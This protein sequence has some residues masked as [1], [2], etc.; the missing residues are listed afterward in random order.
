MAVLLKSRNT[1]LKK[2][3]KRWHWCYNNISE[4]SL[5]LFCVVLTWMKASDSARG[6]ELV[7]SLLIRHNR[8]F[9]TTCPVFLKTQKQCVCVCVCDSIYAHHISR[10]ESKSGKTC[11]SGSNWIKIR[12][13]SSIYYQNKNK[14]ENDSEAEKGKTCGASKGSLGRGTHPW[15]ERALFFVLQRENGTLTQRKG[16]RKCYTDVFELKEKK[17]KQFPAEENL[18]LS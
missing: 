5:A 8:L 14:I 17:T 10:C 13:K 18:I 7:S 1:T 15:H 16:E 3:I 2:S 4:A 9:K 6:P 11:V 12:E